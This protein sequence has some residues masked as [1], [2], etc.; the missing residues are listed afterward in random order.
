LPTRKKN[1]TDVNG[2]GAQNYYNFKAEKAP[3]SFDVPQSFVGAYT[4]DLPIGKGKLLGFNNTLANRLLGGWT[5]SG[6]ITLQSGKPLTV[7]T[8]NTLPATGPV[9][10]NVLSGQAL[11]GPND[12]RGSF[13]PNTD[14]YINKGAFTVPLHSRLEMHHGTSTSSALLGCG[15]GMLR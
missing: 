12:S 15:I 10:P 8:E 14:L 6:V 1:I 9:L 13:N 2:V 3:A 11:Y 5:T 7:T 4:Y